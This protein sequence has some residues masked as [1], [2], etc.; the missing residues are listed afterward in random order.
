M[1][2]QNMSKAGKF[3]GKSMYKNI[4]ERTVKRQIILDEIK[5]SPRNKN[6]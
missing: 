6:Y 3:R 2:I 1:D 5:M 4:K